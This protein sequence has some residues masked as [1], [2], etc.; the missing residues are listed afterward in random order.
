MQ[1][2]KIDD[3]RKVLLI[4]DSLALYIGIE[5]STSPVCLNVEKMY[6]WTHTNSFM[7][8]PNHSLTCYKLRIE[9]LTYNSLGFKYN[10]SKFILSME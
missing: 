7:D 6:S 4:E 1:T 5:K 10:H 9:E 2:F 3:F 8:M